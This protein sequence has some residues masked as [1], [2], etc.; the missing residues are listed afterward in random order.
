MQAWAISVVHF[1]GVSG[2][3]WFTYALYTLTGCRTP[4]IIPCIWHKT[5]LSCK[6]TAAKLLP[7][8]EFL[9]CVSKRTSFTSKT[10]THLLTSLAVVLLS[11]FSLSWGSFCILVWLV[12][13]LFF[14][15]NKSLTNS[16][17]SA[18]NRR[19]YTAWTL[20]Y[21]NGKCVCVLWG[22][23]LTPC[24]FS[25][26]ACEKKQ[27]RQVRNIHL[28]YCFLPFRSHQRGKQYTR[29]KEEQESPSPFIC[30]HFCLLLLAHCHTDYIF[31]NL[32]RRGIYG[33][34]SI[35]PLIS[36]WVQR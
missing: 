36:I 22:W 5:A 25:D 21:S 11:T 2:L 12:L 3:P 27:K 23:L 28:D 26:P 31:P 24:G 19:H 17:I 32:A 14:D 1:K 18:N 35:S 16:C 33:I 7:C 29:W 30:N 15:K 6:T 9:Y 13:F 8:W 4:C 34:Y 20:Y 10:T